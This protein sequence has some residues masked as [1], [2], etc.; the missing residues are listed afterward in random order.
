[1]AKK[2]ANNRLMISYG[3]NMN[4]QQMQHRCPGAEIVGKAT[5]EGWRLTFQGSQ[6]NAHAN[7]LRED[8]ATTPVL[9]W[10]ISQDHEDTLDIY[11]GVAGGYYRKHYMPVTVN[12]KTHRRALVYL[13][14]TRPYNA[15]QARYLNGIA[16]AY[17]AACIDTEPLYEALRYAAENTGTMPKISRRETA[18]NDHH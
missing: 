5:L 3:S 13:M 11:E 14:N 1:M 15:P 6:H 9:I 2:R 17:K 7:I 10:A 4:V 8:G 16:T 18:A 12:G